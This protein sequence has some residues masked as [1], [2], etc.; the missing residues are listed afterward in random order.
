MKSVDFGC[1]QVGRSAPLLQKLVEVSARV[2]REGESVLHHCSV[3]TSGPAGGA[4]WP[5][6]NK[7]D[8]HASVHGVRFQYVDGNAYLSHWHKVIQHMC[9]TV[10]C[11]AWHKTAL[12]S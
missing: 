7:T 2:C 8:R 6:V 12:L 5:E 1:S 9:E 10:G 11:D 4:G 3:M